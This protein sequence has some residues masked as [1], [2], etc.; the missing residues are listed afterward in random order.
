[1]PELLELLAQRDPKNDPRGMQQRYLSFVLFERGGEHGDGM[2]SRSLDGVD[3]ELLYQAVRAGLKNEDGRARGTIGSVYRNLSAEE[4]KPLLPAILQAVVE[5]APSGEMFADEIRVEGLRVLAEHRVEEGIN[6]CVTYTRD[7]N[8]WESQNRTPDTD[9]DPAPL[10][11]PRKVGHSGT[12]TDCRLLRKG[13]KGLSQGSG[14]RKGKGR[15][16]DDP[17]DR[18][19]ARVPR[20]DPHPGGK[21]MIVGRRK[22]LTMCAGLWWATSVAGAAAMRLEDYNVVWDA[23]SANARGSMP[24]GNGDLGLNA[25]VEAEGGL[26]FCIGKTDAWDD[27]N[28]LL[29]VGRVRVTLNPNPFAKGGAFRQELRCA[30]ARWWLPRPPPMLPMHRW[31]CIYGPMPTGRSSTLRSIRRSRSSRRS[32]WRFGGPAAD[33][34]KA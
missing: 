16:R 10:R 30:A 18:S 1:M 3:R 26:V 22:W 15:S 12:E 28:R 33:R 5:P 24:L 4:I 21:P 31:R 25:W 23:P 34:G 7:Q 20:T 6:A 11:R 14:A 13:R 8:P 9:G 29:K 32:C 19:L 2:L 27:N 17:C